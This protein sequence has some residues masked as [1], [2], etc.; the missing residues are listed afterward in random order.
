MI[1]LHCHLL[2]DW[3]DGPSSI[4]DAL[5]M[6]KIAKEEG[7]E[8]I[9]VTPH[10]YR[11]NKWKDDIE[12]MR[13]KFEQLAKEARYFS[14]DLYLSPEIYVHPDMLNI[15]R[16]EISINS[17]NYIFIEFPSTHVPPGWRNLVYEI[18]LRGFVPVISHPEKNDGIREN[19]YILYEMIKEGV[20]SMGT[21]MSL[22]GEFGPSIKKTINYLLS[23]NLITFIATDAHNSKDRPPRLRKAVEEASKIV[24]QDY[25]LAMVTKIPQAIL[26][27]RSIPEPLEPIHPKKKNIG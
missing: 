21:A 11:M 8:K 26:D 2:V 1:D 19:P 15:I 7:I 5:Q 22:T 18:T 6:L 17:G 23:H 9:V 13:E 27:N 4:S 25:A 3:D 24:G 12:I 14:I 20:L 10:L 16:K